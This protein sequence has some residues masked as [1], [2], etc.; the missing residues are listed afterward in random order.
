MSK[1]RKVVKGSAGKKILISLTVVGMVAAVTVISASLMKEGKSK[2]RQV[3]Q[4]ISLVKPPPPPPPPKPEVKPP[5]P[6][7]KKEVKIPEPDKTPD[8]KPAD[9]P[10]VSEQLALDAAGT[11][12]TDGFGLGSKQGGRD[13]TTIGGGA[14]GGGDRYAWYA[15]EV[16][17]R[18]QDA[19]ARNPKLQG[20]EYRIIVK[21]W[22]NSDGRIEQSE[23]QDAARN[24]GLA[25]IVKA[26]IAETPRLGEMPP[27]DMPQPVRL[28]LTSRF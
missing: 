20:S 22:I 9:A 15:R 24:P 4:T 27:T 16:Q 2:K 13:V 7:M 28:R 21:I 18:I 6:E 17:K 14:G 3:V 10:P 11:A 26:A 25:D 19:L 5:E 1:D 12:G 8:P 23:V